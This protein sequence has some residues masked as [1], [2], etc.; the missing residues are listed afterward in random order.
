MRIVQY[1]ARRL[2]DHGHLWPC[3]GHGMAGHGPSASTFLIKSPVHDVKMCA[4]M[5]LCRILSKDLALPWFSK[6]LTHSNSRARY[7][8]M[9]FWLMLI[10]CMEEKMS[11]CQTAETEKDSDFG[12]SRFH[13][14]WWWTFLSSW[15]APRCKQ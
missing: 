14:H 8:I 2:T 15:K 7:V 9:R 3:G 11:E 12:S 5:R 1:V 4:H 6:L 10:L 13:V